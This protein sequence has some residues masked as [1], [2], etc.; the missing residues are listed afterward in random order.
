MNKAVKTFALSAISVAL[1]S[2]CVLDD[3]YDG[4]ST[5]GGGGGGGGGATTAIFRVYGYGD[6]NVK[7]FDLYAVGQGG[8]EI[9]IQRDDVTTGTADNIK[10]E[11]FASTEED[12][13]ILV[14]ISDDAP[15]SIIAK[16]DAN[17]DY[18]ATTNEG[19]NGGG[20]VRARIFPQTLPEAGQRI[21]V[22]IPGSEPLDIT[23]LYTT[24]AGGTGE[25][26]I[27]LPMSCFEGADLSTGTTPFKITSESNLK[28][29]LKDVALRSNTYTED[30]TFDC[31]LSNE[32]AEA[33]VYSRDVEGNVTGWASNASGLSL[34][35][36]SQNGAT[37]AVGGTD[38]HGHLLTFGTNG[39][40]GLHF[41]APKVDEA[42]VFTDLSAY[43]TAKL[44]FNMIVNDTVEDLPDFKVRMVGEKLVHEKE[45]DGTWTGN[46][47]YTS[48]NSAEVVIEAD[49]LTKGAVNVVEVPFSELFA[50]NAAGQMLVNL[51]RNINRLTIMGQG[52]TQ[53]AGG[54]KY[55]GMTMHISDI[56][57]VK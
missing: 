44:R 54:D 1:L 16:A 51:P 35:G 42:D 9:K 19:K 32:I 13:P 30:F 52:G 2:G 48:T 43:S 7:E 21:T 45:E 26:W 17:Y 27:K 56:E 40:A 24:L 8:N 50:G 25:Q 14:T 55:Q 11:W 10:T 22:E 41:T 53:A 3:K 29:A 57:F 4:G 15:G 33:E 34:S 6:Y 38:Y 18:T 28:F 49:T 46:S 23:E 37:V 47:A 20:T 36:G 12:S 31:A 39:N 5:G